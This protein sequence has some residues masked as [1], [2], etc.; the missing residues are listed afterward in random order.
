[1]PA[2]MARTSSNQTTQNSVFEKVN[3][4]SELYDV[5]SCYDPNSGHFVA[6]ENGIYNLNA[7]LKTDVG[8]AGRVIGRFNI[9]GDDNYRFYDSS[10]GDSGCTASGSI[11]V[12]LNKNDVVF[13]E[14]WKNQGAGLV[15]QYGTSWFSGNL[16]AL[17]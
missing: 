10:G 11:T 8:R 13:V 14:L 4:T 2:F 6:P 3:F 7:S 16:V 9:A 1:M 12:K 5:G 17:S 15:A